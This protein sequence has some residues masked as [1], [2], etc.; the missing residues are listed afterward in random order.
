MAAVGVGG[1]LGSCLVLD[2]QLL[3]PL[4]LL[5]LLPGPAQPCCPCPFFS[6]STPTR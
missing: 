4:L 2:V 3:R 6:W 5:C 1:S